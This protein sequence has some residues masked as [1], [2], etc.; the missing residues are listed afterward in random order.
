MCIKTDKDGLM[1]NI[2][3][4][5][6][7]GSQIQ[8]VVLP[9]MLARAPYF[10]RI[11]MWRKFKGHA[12]Y[13][14]GGLIG[15]RGQSA[16]IIQKSATRRMQVQGSMGMPAPGGMPGSGPFGPGGGPPRGPGGPVYQTMN[17]GARAAGAG[18]YGPGGR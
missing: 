8:F 1:S 15:P 11:K 12:V 16:A 18:I 10:N 7:R 9:D 3:M 13:G 14:A 17:P 2:E 4:A 6:I 5:Y